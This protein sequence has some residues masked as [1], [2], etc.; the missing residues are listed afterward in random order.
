MN[1]AD[2][3]LN[4]EIGPILEHPKKNNIKTEAGIPLKLVSN[5]D[6]S[7]DQPVAIKELVEGINNNERSQV[8]LGVTGSGKTEVYFEL[9]ISLLINKSKMLY[10]N[11]CTHYSKYFFLDLLTNYLKDMVFEYYDDL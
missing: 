3:F 10:I 6:P 9:Y 2:S 11:N 1:K 7:G 5:F 8:L 4:D